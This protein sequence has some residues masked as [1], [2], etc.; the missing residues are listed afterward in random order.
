MRRAYRALPTQLVVVVWDGRRFDPATAH[1]PRLLLTIT[2]GP[3]GL[4][5]LE[6]LCKRLRPRPVVAPAHRPGPAGGPRTCR[7]RQ[8]L[9]PI[10]LQTP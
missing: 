5:I 9:S 7:T 10:S 8:T 4:A 1:Q 3:V 6:I 2:V